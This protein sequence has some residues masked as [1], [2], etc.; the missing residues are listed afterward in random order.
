[1]QQRPL[2]PFPHF[3]PR[4]CSL[5]HVANS[6]AQT[7]N[8]RQQTRQPSPHFGGSDH[9][10]VDALSPPKA[11]SSDA[12]VTEGLIARLP[13]CPSAHLPTHNTCNICPYTCMFICPPAHPQ[14]LQHL[15]HLPIYP[16][17]HLPTCPPTTPA[18]PTSATSA[19]PHLLT[20]AGAAANG[21]RFACVGRRR[22]HGGGAAV[23]GGREPR[24]GVG[25]RDAGGG[26]Q[27]GGCAC[28]RSACTAGVGPGC[29]KRG[30]S[31][32]EGSGAAPWMGG[33]MVGSTMVMFELCSAC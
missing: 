12:K 33:W 18:T 20:S 16:Y 2:R 23:A 6:R 30:G 15:Q 29:V 17:V 32:E 10:V 9:N 4:G 25:P 8:R 14:H 5:T 26:G 31:C 3:T 11:S 1:M 19:R 21:H 27:Q 13:I 28:G 7:C 22:R 24:A